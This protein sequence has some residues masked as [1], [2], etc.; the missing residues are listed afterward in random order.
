MAISETISNQNENCQKNVSG[1]EVM[2]H[3]NEFPA[4]GPATE[5]ARQ[6]NIERTNSL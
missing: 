4:A 6:R 5:K 3:G 1:P 2:V